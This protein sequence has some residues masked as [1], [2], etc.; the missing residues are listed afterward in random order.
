[1]IY[2]E[3]NII[4]IYM[5]EFKGPSINNNINSLEVIKN[6]PNMNNDIKVILRRIT[7]YLDNPNTKITTDVERFN[8]ILNSIKSSDK[9]TL[10]LL[11]ELKIRLSTINKP[12]N[13]PVNSRGNVGKIPSTVGNTSIINY[14]LLSKISPNEQVKYIENKSREESEY[15]P[16]NGWEIKPVRGDGNCGYHSIMEYL[17]NTGNINIEDILESYKNIKNNSR[18]NAQNKLGYILRY[19]VIEEVNRLINIFERMS[20]LSSLEREQFNKDILKYA[21]SPLNQENGNKTITDLVS[22]KSLIERYNKYSDN[23]SNTEF[24][25]EKQLRFVSGLLNKYI[26]IYDTRV[27]KWSKIG[28]AK[29]LGEPNNENSIFIILKPGHFDSLLPTKLFKDT[30]NVP[31]T[32]NYFNYNFL[33][34]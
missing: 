17:K 5:A 10:A 15:T 20:T 16:P 12:S 7:S 31:N 3:K 30:F 4:Y 13:V 27:K 1:M 34:N 11:A 2:T 22:V 23:P 26:Y 8:G 33:K 21:L 24:M 6:I 29:I 14:N 19:S 28:D 18:I 25:E 9:N 32:N